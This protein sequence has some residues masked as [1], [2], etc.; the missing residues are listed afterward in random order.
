MFA[1][2]DSTWY[3]PIYRNA[4]ITISAYV[5][6]LICARTLAPIGPDPSLKSFVPA[7]PPQGMLVKHFR[8]GG[9]PYLQPCLAH[10][11]HPGS[12][13]GLTARANG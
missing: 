5:K 12:A 10:L 2:C 11:H 6:D 7:G 13:S 4:Q 9:A 3:K 8:T 1:G